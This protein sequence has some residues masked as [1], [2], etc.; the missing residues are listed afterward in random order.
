[1]HAYSTQAGID[2]GRV[3][4]LY[5]THTRTRLIRTGCGLEA[6]GLLP[7]VVSDALAVAS[8]HW[9]THDFRCNSFARSRRERQETNDQRLALTRP[10][11]FVLF[12]ND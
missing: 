10:E 2:L 11:R 4:K 6:T 3:F 8:V 7:V 12:A 1:M 5:V 9:R